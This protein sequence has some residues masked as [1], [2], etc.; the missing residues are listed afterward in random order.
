MSQIAPVLS[1]LA[2]TGRV[3]T[4]AGRAVLA[5]VVDRSAAGVH[6]A[7]SL[8]SNL[9]AASG[10][11]GYARA[12]AAALSREQASAVIDPGFRRWVAG[13]GDDPLTQWRQ[14]LYD[15]LGE[16]RDHVMTDYAST[17]AI[18]GREV[19]GRRMDAGLAEVFYLAARKRACQPEP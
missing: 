7:G 10:G 11:D 8:A 2:G 5:E 12:C 14:A 16:V 3:L 4:T 17:A 6:A 1:V 19:D 13:F 9:V 15:L 18:V